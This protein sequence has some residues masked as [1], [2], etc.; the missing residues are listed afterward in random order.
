MAG[1]ELAEGVLVVMAGQAELLKVI[2]TRHAVR[3]LADLLDSR[4]Q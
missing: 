2:G 3:R 4:Q 1:R